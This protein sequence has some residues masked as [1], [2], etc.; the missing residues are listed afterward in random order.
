MTDNTTSVLRTN[1]AHR[2]VPPAQSSRGW[3]RTR[4][5]RRYGWEIAA[6]IVVKLLLLMLLWLVFIK[7][8]PRPATSPATVVQQFY[9]PAA[10]VAHH[11]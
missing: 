8:F 9:L 5:G 6:V 10:P 7:P 4:E 2:P 1:A 11:D 3:F